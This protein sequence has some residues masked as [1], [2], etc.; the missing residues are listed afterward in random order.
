MAYKY[1]VKPEIKG[2]KDILDSIIGP[3]LII[4]HFIAA[5]GYIAWLELLL[6]IGV[7]QQLYIGISN[8][9]VF[10]SWKNS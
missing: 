7:S 6:V 2:V 9:L 5:L 10:I 8:F 4:L 3:T 1:K